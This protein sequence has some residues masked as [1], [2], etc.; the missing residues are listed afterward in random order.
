MARQGW[1][2]QSMVR[3]RRG[4]GGARPGMAGLVMARHGEDA[5]WQSLAG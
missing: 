3:M 2:R 5:A 4:W 1:K